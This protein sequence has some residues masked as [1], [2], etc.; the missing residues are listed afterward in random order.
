MK[1]LPN[2]IKIGKDDFESYGIDKYDVLKVVESTEGF[3]YYLNIDNVHM[4]AYLK[5]SK[6][7]QIDEA[8]NQYELAM[9]VIGLVL[10]QDFK[11]QKGELS[12]GEFTKEYTRR[13]SPLI[14][15][16]VRDIATV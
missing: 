11:K 1:D 7:D 15:P 4:Q 2:L 6:N 8:K 3:D 14:L 16:L 13:I 12:L 10:I 9:A 5:D